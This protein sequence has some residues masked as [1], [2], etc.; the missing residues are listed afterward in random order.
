MN[1]RWD[2]RPASVFSVWRPLEDGTLEGSRIFKA[3][4]E[5]W[6]GSP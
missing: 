3:V 5:L 1:G 2:I 6:G 4:T